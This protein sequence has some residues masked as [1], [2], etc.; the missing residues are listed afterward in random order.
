MT[1]PNRIST[2]T[3]LNSAGQLNRERPTP[4]AIPAAAALNDNPGLEHIR[5]NTAE[6]GQ[7]ETDDSA[8]GE[9]T[10]DDT[11]YNDAEGDTEDIGGNARSGARRGRRK[12]DAAAAET[13]KTA[14][15]PPL[16]A[17]ETTTPAAAAA[18]TTSSLISTTPTSSRN[19]SS[20]VSNS[21]ISRRSR[22]Q[23]A[24]RS[25]AEDG[26]PPSPR[27]ARRLRN[28]L[29]A[30]RM[31]TRQKQHLEDLEQRKEVLERQAAALE[32]ELQ[33]LQRNNNPLNT[34]IDALAEMIDDLTNVEFTM[35]SGIDE[36][37]GLL[38]NLERLYQDRQLG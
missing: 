22:S 11:D 2:N 13:A 3:P 18:L 8:M 16:A 23:Q 12:A 1:R 28:R 36:C 24:G 5:H 31:R 37:K 19:S 26:R 20:R 14:F 15:S 35:L 6:Q 34:S 10:N 17:T 21:R 4:S 9:R 7:S 32:E 30:A 25:M 29:A 27:S 33:Q 38:Q